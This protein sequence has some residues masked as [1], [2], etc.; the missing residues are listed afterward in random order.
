MH[1][2]LGIYILLE[3]MIE[4]ASKPRKTHRIYLNNGKAEASLIWMPIIGIQV[5]LRVTIIDMKIISL[6]K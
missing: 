2:Q 6:N 1:T 3:L 4:F 5:G